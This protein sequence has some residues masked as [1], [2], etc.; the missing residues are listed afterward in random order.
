MVMAEVPSVPSWEMVLH[1][2][3][4]D[5]LRTEALLL[6]AVADLS[7]PAEAEVASAARTLA[8]PP[9]GELPP[10]HS[11]PAVPPTLVERVQALR[12]RIAQ[13]RTELETAMAANRRMSAGTNIARPVA[14][15]PQAR[16]ID[17]VV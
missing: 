2:V 1:T 17:T 11:M 4:Q 16:F 8:Q 13:V 15:Q 9:A 6:L 12:T 10:L 14:A 3:E 7:N 5:V